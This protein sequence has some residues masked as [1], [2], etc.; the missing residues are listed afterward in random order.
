MVQ[1]SYK[2]R[3]QKIICSKYIINNKVNKLLAAI[4]WLNSKPE[5]NQVTP[6]LFG[7]MASN[8]TKGL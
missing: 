5:R 3:T 7:A 4:C 2:N 6:D 1:K 8:W